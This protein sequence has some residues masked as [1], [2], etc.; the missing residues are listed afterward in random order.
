MDTLQL[1]R[2]VL[3]TEW[4]VST[5]VRTDGPVVLQVYLVN[6]DAPDNGID[7]TRHPAYNGLMF[8]TEDDA[9]SYA[10]MQGLLKT[11]MPRSQRRKQEGFTVGRINY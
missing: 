3:G 4:N 10:W 11:W 5:I 7:F 9:R 8:D 2:L 1:P 6:Y